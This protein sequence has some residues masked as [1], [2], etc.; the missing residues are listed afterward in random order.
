MYKR[1]LYKLQ[2]FLVKSWSVVCVSNVIYLISDYVDGFPVRSHTKFRFRAIAHI[3]K[4]IQVDDLCIAIGR[5]SILYNGRFLYLH[6]DFT[7]LYACSKSTQG[8]Q[9]RPFIYIRCIHSL[10]CW[11]LRSI[12]VLHFNFHLGLFFKFSGFLYEF[13][14][15]L[16]NNW[17][18]QRKPIKSRNECQETGHG[19]C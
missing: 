15:V 1:K 2:Y 11:V 8:F 5:M 16:Q 6:D 12:F 4:H 9:N 10:R 13:M 3:L 18:L 14:P 19:I 7:T 17:D